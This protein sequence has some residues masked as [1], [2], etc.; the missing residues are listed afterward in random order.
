MSN[1]AYKTHFQKGFDHCLTNSAGIKAGQFGYKYVRSVEIAIDE[2]DKAM[3]NPYIGSKASTATIRGFV[4]EE[5][6]AGSFNIHAAVAGSKERA[7]TVNLNPV[8]DIDSGEVLAAPARMGL[9][10]PDIVTTFGE[11]YGLK[12]YKDGVSSVIAQAKTLNERYQHY[13]ANHPEVDL[14]TYCRLFNVDERLTLDDSLYKFQKMLIPT[15]QL[16]EGELYAL[17]RV[18][19]ALEQKSDKTIAFIEVHQ[20][21]TDRI[22]SPDGIESDPY[23]REMADYDAEQ[24]RAGSYDPSSDGYTTEELIRYKQIINQGLKA[25][26]RAAI[27]TLTIK[28]APDVCDLIIRFMKNEKIDKTKFKEIG[29]KALSASAQGYINGFLAAS[30]TTACVSGQLGSSLL[31]VDPTIIGSITSFVSITLID[32]IKANSGMI[33]YATY[34]DSIARNIFVTGGS[35]IGGKLFETMFYV[36]MISYMIGSFIGASL[37]AGLYS[38]L[39]EAYMSYIIEEGMTLFGLVNQDYSIPEEALQDIGVDL[40]QHHEYEYRQYKVKE[41]KY[42]QYKERESDY[43]KALNFSLLKRGMIGINKVGYLI[44]D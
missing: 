2:L 7:A 5:H 18:V 29:L 6:G 36:P 37:A 1:V 41:F 12:Y 33:D 27:T 34:V 32:G 40:F 31:N 24:V 11:D 44:D 42:H 13:V 3:N 25:G 17:K 23:S 14:D 26:E 28:L 30:L 43:N 4:A 19:K 38:P 8:I 21:L 9:A 10:S 20:N 22:I 39:H 16:T 15:D 35:V